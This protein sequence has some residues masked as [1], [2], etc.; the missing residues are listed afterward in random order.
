MMNTNEARMTLI[1]SRFGKYLTSYDLLK[2]F[3]VVTMIVDHI[4]FYLFPHVVELRI[5]GRLS[6]PCWM[7]LAGFSKS[8]EVGKNI[9]IA[10]FLLVLANCVMGTYL[11]PLNILALIII[12]RL[13]LK[14]MGPMVFL[15]KEFVFY[16]CLVMAIVALPSYY[17][18]EY[19]T[20]GIMIAFA[21][22]IAR[23]RGETAFGPVA[24]KFFLAFVLGFFVL[25]Q[26]AIF[27]FSPVYVA[28]LCVMFALLGLFLY[29]FEPKEYLRAT[30]RL[31]APALWT[32]QFCGR[33]SLEI[34]VV[35]VIILWGVSLYYGTHSAEWLNPPVFYKN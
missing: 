5:I 20:F 1:S 22:Y 16:C 8:L 32:L 9:L 23:H 7:F 31:P 10:C 24:E 34:Y 15:R 4:G 26:T 33:Y 6:S 27:M 28:A 3:A 19:S 29:R 17:L 12:A 11:L 21:G 2:F 25:G 14:Y 35:H 13:F 30:A 18:I